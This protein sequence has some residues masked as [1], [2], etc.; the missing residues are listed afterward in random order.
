[1]CKCASLSVLS[2]EH[3]DYWRLLTPG[4]HIVSASAPGYSRAIKRVRL[5]AHMQ[6]AGRVDFV[7]KKVPVEPDIEEL[8]TLHLIDY[9]R[10]DPYN[11][12]ARYYRRDSRQREEEREGKPWW[13]LYFTQIGNQNPSWLL[14]N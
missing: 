6:A 2:A 8:N 3:G 1:M 4:I 11:Q 5:P 13:W 12:L 9:E 10:F 7:L 14:R